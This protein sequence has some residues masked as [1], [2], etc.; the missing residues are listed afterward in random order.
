MAGVVAADAGRRH[1]AVV[2]RPDVG[3]LAPGVAQC[4][5]VHQRLGL[6]RKRGVFKHGGVGRFALLLAGRFFRHGARGLDRLGLH[7]AGVVAADAG[8]RHAAVFGLPDIGR[9]APGVV[10]SRNHNRCVNLGAAILIG[11]Q[12]IA[13]RAAPILPCTTLRAGCRVSLMMY[14]AVSNGQGSVRQVKINIFIVVVI[15]VFLIIAKN[16]AATA[17]K[18]T[19]FCLEL[20]CCKRS[21]NG[22]FT[23][24][25]HPVQR[26]NA[27]HII[28]GSICLH[29]GSKHT[30]DL[31]KGSFQGV[32]IEGNDE[33]QACNSGV[34]VD[35]DGNLSRFAG[36]ML[37]LSTGNTDFRRSILAEIALFRLP[38]HGK[39]GKSQ[40]PNAHCK[41]KHQAQDCFD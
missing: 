28:D 35:I 26:N 1:A 36:A 33:L 13:A 8:R 9:L 3:R 38:P 22:A 39:T 23:Q 34:S 11:E 4:V 14:R 24:N 41:R 5:N 30:V 27:I 12:Q 40:E 37:E 32:Y 15:D 18:R 31:R 7:M 2:V 6:R 16:Q 21:V 19:V 20:N 29:S 25:V 17:D 10:Q